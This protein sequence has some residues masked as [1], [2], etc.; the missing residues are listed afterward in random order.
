MNLCDEL[1]TIIH[2]KITNFKHKDDTDF[3]DLT[4]YALGYKKTDSENTFKKAPSFSL[5]TSCTFYFLA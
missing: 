4:D 5:D 3:K 2:A 1:L